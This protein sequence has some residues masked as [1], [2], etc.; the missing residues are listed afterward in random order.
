MF[1]EA[2]KHRSS[3][4]SK[5]SSTGKSIPLVPGTYRVAG[6][7]Q[8]GSFDVI[9]FEMAAGDQKEIVLRDKGD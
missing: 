6:W 3:G 7:S 8:M 1:T 4:W 5:V 9:D 2:A